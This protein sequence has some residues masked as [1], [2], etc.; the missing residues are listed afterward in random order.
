MMSLSGPNQNTSPTTLAMAPHFRRARQCLI[1]FLPQ[2]GRL[3]QRAFRT[4]GAD[5]IQYEKKKKHFP[6]QIQIKGLFK[7]KESFDNRSTNL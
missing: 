1:C 4:M 6:S 2:G 3:W 5:V 7:E